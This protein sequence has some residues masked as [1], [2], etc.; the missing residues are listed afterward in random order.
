MKRFTTFALILALAL[1][2]L[3]GCR[4]RREDETGTTTTETIMPDSGNILPDEDMLPD[5]NDTIDPSSGATDGMV[6]PTNGANQD[7]TADT[8]PDTTHGTEG[9]SRRHPMR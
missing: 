5:R 3:A 4:S 7:P 9:R 6:D 1:S 2:L 8:L